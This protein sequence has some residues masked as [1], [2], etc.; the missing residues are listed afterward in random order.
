[1]VEE[2]I[3]RPRQLG[4]K[5]AFYRQQHGLSQR[6]LAAIIDIP[7][8]TI[9]RLESGRAKLIKMSL[10]EKIAKV[11]NVTV[12]K[13]IESDQS[14]SHLPRHLQ[15]FVCNPENKEAIHRAYIMSEAQKLK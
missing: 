11:L 13:L 5:V 6:D 2:A 9:A 14:I 8:P 15:D 3:S 4:E 12:N 7:Q 10:V 1:M